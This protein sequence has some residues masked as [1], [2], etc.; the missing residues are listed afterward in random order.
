MWPRSHP[1]AHDV[2]YL[3]GDFLT[4][5]FEAESFDMVTAV[6]SCITWIRK[7][8]FSVRVSCCGPAVCS[9]SSAVRE[10]ASASDALLSG[11]AVLWNRL[12]L[13]TKTGHL[14][15]SQC[16]PPPLWPPP[17]GYREVRQ[18]AERALPGVQSAVF[19]CG[20]TR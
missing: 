16:G 14:G 7:R 19:C 12:L 18:L 3:L 11:I 17:L 8:H 10:T 4:F 15:S 20:A 13:L 9:R 6:A 5:P 2:D 1:K